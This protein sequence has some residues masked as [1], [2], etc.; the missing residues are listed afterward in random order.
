M[1]SLTNTLLRAAVLSVCCGATAAFA[2]DTFTCRAQNYYVDPM[3]QGLRVLVQG[4]PPVGISISEDSAG[5]V[6]AHLNIEG[7]APQEVQGAK[8]I[9]SQFTPDSVGQQVFTKAVGYLAAMTLNSAIADSDAYTSYQI[10]ETDGD[11]FL[12]A[13]TFYREGLAVG[14][15][16]LWPRVEVVGVCE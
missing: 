9:V 13:F 1:K 11:I 2:T 8:V 16:I 4:P 14:Q 12:V 3:G 10:Q 5:L 6:T 15:A 7:S